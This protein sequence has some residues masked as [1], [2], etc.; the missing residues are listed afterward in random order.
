MRYKLNVIDSLKGKPLQVLDNVAIINLNACITRYDNSDKVISG[1]LSSNV[2]KVNLCNLASLSFKLGLPYTSYDTINLI[3]NI[4]ERVKK[5][6]PS[7]KFIQ[8]NFNNLGETDCAPMNELVQINYSS[9]IININA[10]VK[11]Y[12]NTFGFTDSQFEQVF[13]SNIDLKEILPIDILNKLPLKRTETMDMYN[14]LKG[15]FE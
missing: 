7:V 12:L 15:L 14:L 5:E 13:T 4:I 1:I 6:R 11:K 8:S 2:D 3:D 9:G 10:V